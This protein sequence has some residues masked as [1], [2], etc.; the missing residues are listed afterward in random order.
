MNDDGSAV[1]AIIVLS[2]KRKSGKDFVAE[3]IVDRLKEENCV[4]IRVASPIKKHF[5]NK[6]NMSYDEMITS[7]QYK[8]QR[9]QEMIKW[10]EMQRAK[11]KYVFCE[12]ITQEAVETRKPVWILSDARRPTDVEYFKEY[13]RTRNCSFYSIR[14]S[15]DLDTRVK[16]G[17]KFTVGVDDVD[18]ECALDDY[19]SWS[20]MFENSSSDNV[21]NV[22]KTFCSEVSLV[23]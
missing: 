22:V 1:R 12:T 14:I 6:Y 5:C 13:S 19:Q 15:A 10:G 17:W 4:I 2:G 16:R 18:S 8:E 11:D 9:R 3:N 20:H 21:L 7:S 23:L